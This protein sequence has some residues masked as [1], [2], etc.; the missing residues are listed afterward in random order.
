MNSETSRSVLWVRNFLLAQCNTV[1]PA[2]VWQ[3]NKSIL[4]IMEKGKSTSSRRSTSTFGTSSSLI[5][6]DKVK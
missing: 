3:D 4:A 5:G 1:G 2:I 6:S